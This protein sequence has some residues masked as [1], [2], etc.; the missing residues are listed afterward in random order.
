MSYISKIID[1]TELGLPVINYNSFFHENICHVCKKLN[2]GYFISCNECDMISY[3][4]REHR[5]LHRPQ[6]M[7]ICEYINRFLRENEIRR[8]CALSLTNWITLRQQFLSSIK[9]WI[10]RKLKPYEEQMILFAKSCSICHRQINLVH[11]RTCYSEYYCIDHIQIFQ[12]L[13]QQKCQQFVLYIN[14]NIVTSINNIPQLKFTNIFREKRTFN[15]MNTFIRIYGYISPR[16]GGIAAIYYK[17]FYCDYVSGPLTLYYGMK[18]AGLL[19]PVISTARLTLDFKY[20]IHVVALN[21][22]EKEYI[23]AWEIFIHLTRYIKD[24]TIILVGP[25]FEQEHYDKELC[26]FCK[27]RCTMLHI[28]IYS[29]FYHMYV[30]G[31]SF[32]KPNIIVEFQADFSNEWTCSRSIFLSRIRH[33]P[34]ILTTTSEEKAQQNVSIL[35][36]ILG[37]HI[38]PLYNTPNPFRSWRPWRDLETDSVYFRND[39]VTFYCNTSIL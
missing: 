13:H 31:P 4:T 21:S 26:S 36:Q 23:N 28:E 14:T 22:L 24:L 20:V 15:D 1:V 29:T 38:H 12:G 8:D 5:L 30:A 35:K 10:P 34:L 37:S 19:E 16:Y 17:Y 6:H 9:K 25:N 18:N 27:H 7:Q 32:K 2:N 11:C 3:C 39:Y 33:C